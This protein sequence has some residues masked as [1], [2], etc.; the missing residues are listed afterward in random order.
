MTPRRTMRPGGQDE[1]SVSAEAT[2]ANTNPP[3]SYSVDIRAVNSGN[4]DT[5]QGI[6]QQPISKSGI[7]KNLVLTEVTDQ[8]YEILSNAIDTLKGAIPNFEKLINEFGKENDN[9]PYRGKVRSMRDVIG[10]LIKYPFS[11][12]TFY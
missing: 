12:L 6:Q 2:S 3:V 10:T 5:E 7:N 8:S 9:Y 1:I 4:L 11:I